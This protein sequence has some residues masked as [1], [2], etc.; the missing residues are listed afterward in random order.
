MYLLILKTNIESEAMVR[1]VA[2]ALN[3]HEAIDRWHIDT[4][5]VDNVLKVESTMNLDESD[6][7]H[8]IRPYGFTGE[9]LK[10]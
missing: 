3:N 4:E 10:D 5:D 6:I 2:C 9:E 8:L 7:S 1:T